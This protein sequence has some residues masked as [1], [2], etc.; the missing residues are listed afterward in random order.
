MAALEDNNKMG[1][2]AANSATY[3]FIKTIATAT[4]KIIVTVAIVVYKGLI[5]VVFRRLTVLQLTISL[6]KFRD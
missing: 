1:N 5:P 3:R 4:N 6:F 2:L